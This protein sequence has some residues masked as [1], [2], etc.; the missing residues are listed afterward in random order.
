MF[1]RNHAYVLVVNGANAR[2]F[3]PANAVRASFQI[4]RPLMGR[5]EVHEFEDRGVL[6]MHGRWYRP[7]VCLAADGGDQIVENGGFSL[8]MKQAVAC[9]F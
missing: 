4:T 3:G 8:L 7:P 6:K 1:R 2:P 5:S 9:G